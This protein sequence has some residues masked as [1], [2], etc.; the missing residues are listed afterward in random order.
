MDHKSMRVPESMRV[1]D[2]AVGVAD[3]SVGRSK[4]MPMSIGDR[5]MSR[6]RVST[7]RSARR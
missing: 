1:S 5:C 2:K 4:G 6:R 7:P 3:E